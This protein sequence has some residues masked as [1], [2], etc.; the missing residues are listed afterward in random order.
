MPELADD[1]ASDPNPFS[2]VVDAVPEG[3]ALEA[4]CR[5]A[6]A[7]T[8]TVPIARQT[9]TAKDDGRQFTPEHA[10]AFIPRSAPIPTG[11]TPCQRGKNKLTLNS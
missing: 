8:S 3:T 4:E 1:R 11:A 6:G 7:G 10:C 2:D 9:I 5:I